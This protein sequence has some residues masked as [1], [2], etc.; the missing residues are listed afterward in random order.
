M[1]EAIIM[2]ARDDAA[3]GTS[4]KSVLDNKVEVG[5]DFALEAGNVPGF[6]FN[7]AA[8]AAAV[9][10]VNGVTEDE[11]T[12]AQAKAATDAYVANGTVPGNVGDTFT[13][14]AGVDVLN[15]TAASDTFVGAASAAAGTTTLGV[16]DQID[17]GAGVDTLKVFSDGTAPVIPAGVSNVENLY[18]NG[19]IVD[20]NLT[21]NGFTAVEF[22]N[23]TTT[24]AGTDTIT[25]A[26]GNTVTLDS[27]VDGAAADG[28]NQGGIQIASA[29]SVTSASVTVDGV[30][31]ANTTGTNTGDLDIDVTGAGVAA[32]TVNSIGSTN[33]VGLANSGAALKTLTVT[34]DKM[35]DA[36]EDALAGLTTIDASAS[37]GGTKLNITGSTLDVKATG[38]AG[39]DT[40]I[41]GGD[42]DANDT[43][44]LG[45]G[46]DTVVVSDATINSATTALGKGIVA[47][48]NVE[49]VGSS[50]TAADGVVIDA[51][52][53]TNVNTF[54]VGSGGALAPANNAA[55]AAGDVAASFTFAAGDTLSIAANV[56]GGTSAA[57]DA[58]G[59]DA[60]NATA[61]VNSGTDVL[62]LSVDAGAAVTVTG[63]AST[64]GTAD[65]GNVSGD[66][67]DASTVET[68]NISTASALDDITF[69]AGTAAGTDTAGSSVSV[70]ANATINITG[71][72]DVNLGTVVASGGATVDDLTIDG[73]AMTGALTVTTGA[74]N[75]TIKG[76]SKADTIDAG[77]GVN[78]VTLGGGADTLKVAD[79]SSNPT[80]GLTSVTD[81]AFGAGNDKIDFSGAAA[82]TFEALTSANATAIAADASLGDA[83]TQAM[84]QLDADQA[85]AFVYG[86]D[87]YVVFN[88]A[89][90][91]TFDN[92]ADAV[93]KLTG[94]TDVSGLDVTQIM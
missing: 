62:N 44:D 71:A 79:G 31:Q 41:I 80:A 27:V 17:G 53:F 26:A 23:A 91:N 83:L 1:I 48:K 50:V 82:V 92:G 12:V 58:S 75:D 21:T 70:G 39:N 10:A 42:L 8:K 11:A 67:L 29:A 28:A 35:L 73:S 36:D 56:T 14:T 30:G 81:F 55:N 85:T 63:G 24:A 68:I 49:I 20:V 51:T 2:G 60:I 61:A 22:D 69:V 76:G 90:D 38:G 47:L 15:G 77:T 94:V 66:A 6:E 40:L 72:G 59:G 37:T 7:A 13:L 78:T 88:D 4:D 93:V 46:V 86:G 64:D 45:D 5:L 33:Y 65:G 52:K 84:S 32:L 18:V 74:G 57:G 34:G 54:Q 3:A 16:A 43:I 87:A 89:T 25:V 19:D 9:A